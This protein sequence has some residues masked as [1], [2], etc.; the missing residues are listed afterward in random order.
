MNNPNQFYPTPLYLIEKVLEGVDFKKVKTVLEPS[1]GKGDFVE[2]IRERLPYSH[3]EDIDCI[4]IDPNLKY[5]LKGKEF[6][7][8]HDDFLTYQTMKQY[9]L[10]VMNPPFKDG[11]KHLLKAI[12]MQERSGGSIIA[13]V[14]AE[15]I[16]NPYSN[17]RKVLVQKF[18]DN[19]ADI[20][21]MQSA[22]SSAEIPTEVEIAVIKV[23]FPAVFGSSIIIENLKK[24]EKEEQPEINAPNEMVDSDMLKA[25]VQQY[26]MEVQAGIKLIKEYLALKP[27]IMTTFENDESRSY[28]SDAAHLIL[29][30]TD[31]NKY[32]KSVRDKYWRALFKNKEFTGKFTSNLATTFYNKVSELENYEFSLY[33]IYE[34]KIQMNQQMI[35]AVEDTILALFDNLSQKHSWYDETSENI[36]YF[37]GWKSNA[38]HKINKK[39]IIPLNTYD[40][41]WGYRPTGYN[42]LEEL[43]D[44]EKALDYLAGDTYGSHITYVLESAQRNQET[45][46]IKCKH[47]Y[48]TFYKKG[49]CHITF[50]DDELLKKFNIF[51]CQRKGWLPPSYGKCTY[52]E[53]SDEEKAVIDDFEGSDEYS[54]TMDNKDYYITDSASLLS[55]AE[56][57]DI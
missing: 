3:K 52:S 45:K 42:C 8:V 9:D 24:A 40:S 18:T 7:V 41:N 46:N 31:I 17:E 27:Y 22:F 54:R 14:N 48:L 16:R 47:F 56:A 32:I 44:I 39:V 30:P 43:A 29:E 6:R 34:I 10:I 23:T 50:R 5:I 35:K 19:N 26:N 33:N 21:F 11:D 49:T 36:H 13:I 38:A 1:A 37:N 2:Y 4:E 55:L 51:G 25:I 12:E 28:L 15:T 53:M 20:E 57:S